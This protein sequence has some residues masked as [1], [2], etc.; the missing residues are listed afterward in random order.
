MNLQLNF[1]T[2][3]DNSWAFAVRKPGRMSWHRG[4]R[5]MR[6]YIISACSVEAKSFGIRTGMRYGQAKALIPDL[7]V[8]LLGGKTK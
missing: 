7:R 3:T 1:S 5:D 2:T 8:I 6:D 4:A